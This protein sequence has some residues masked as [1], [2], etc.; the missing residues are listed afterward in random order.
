[1]PALNNSIA[2]APLP[3]P[4]KFLTL[5]VDLQLRPELWLKLKLCYDQRPD[6]LG[7]RHLFGDHDYFLLLSDS[8]GFIGVGP[9]LWWEGVP[10]VYNCC[11]ASPDQ[12]FMDLN[13]ATNDHILLSQVSDSPTSRARFPYSYTFPRKRVAELYPHALRSLFVVSYGSQSYGGGNRTA[14]TWGWTV[15]KSKSKSCYDWRS[16]SQYVLV[17]SSLWNLWP[18]IIF[19]LKVAVLS[20]WGVLSDERSVL[21]LVSHCQHY[22]VHCKKFNI[23]YIE[24]VTCF[25]YI[26]QSLDLCQHRLST[27]DHANTSVAYTI[28]AV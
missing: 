20:L 11:W 9:R 7:V 1:M 10:E 26:Q 12:S 18:D 16:V 3:S 27:A 5:T 19:C 25:M 23:I 22:L 21:S 13:P 8:Y 6:C 17:S 14:Y 2:V 28:T 4:S 15:I 24:D